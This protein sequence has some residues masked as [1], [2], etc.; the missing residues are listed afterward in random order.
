[1]AQPVALDR[2]DVVIDARIQAAAD[3]L[4]R[5]CRTATTSVLPAPTKNAP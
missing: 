2:L 5:N 4:E 3:G 1:M